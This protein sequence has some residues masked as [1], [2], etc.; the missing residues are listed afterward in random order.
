MTPITS[1]R[2]MC[3]NS[4]GEQT[5]YRNAMTDAEVRYFATRLA[6]EEPN[7]ALRQAALDS[8]NARFNQIERQRREAAAA[9]CVVTDKTPRCQPE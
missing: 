3:Y 2:M 1:T 5:G 7:P 4:D 8:I 9:Q 6:L